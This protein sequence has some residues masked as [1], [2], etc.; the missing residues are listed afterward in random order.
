MDPGPPR[1]SQELFYQLTPDFV[2]D[3][4]ESCGWRTTG[5]YLQLNSYE[6]RV[7][8]IRVESPPPPGRPDH[9][10]VLPAGTLDVS[11]SAVASASKGSLFRSWVIFARL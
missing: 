6:N 9:R 4:V 7:Y 8:A 1:K 2:L 10:Q 11:R 3:A 5:E